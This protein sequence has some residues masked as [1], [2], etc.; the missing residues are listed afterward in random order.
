MTMQGSAVSDVSTR[1]E[2]FSDFARA[3]M[4]AWKVPGLAVAAVKD[5]AVIF[6]QG[7]GLRD[8]NGGPEVT[9]QTLFAIGSCT[10]AFTAMGLAILADEGKLDWDTPVRTYLPAFRMHDH[11]ATP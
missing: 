6:S 3:T 2:G 4:A 5:G 8:V 7:F 10:K 11:V 9:S 1:L